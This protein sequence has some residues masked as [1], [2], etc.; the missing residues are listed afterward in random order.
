MTGKR[1]VDVQPINKTAKIPT[2]VFSFQ[3][4]WGYVS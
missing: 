2:E 3:E 1:I 4:N